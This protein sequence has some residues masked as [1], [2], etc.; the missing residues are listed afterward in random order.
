MNETNPILLCLPEYKGCIFSVSCL[1]MPVQT[2]F[3]DLALSQMRG[4]R[5]KYP[6]CMACGAHGCRCFSY[7]APSETAP[8]YKEWHGHE[9]IILCK[10]CSKMWLKF[11]ED[12]QASGKD[13]DEA[14]TIGNEKLFTKIDEFQGLLLS[15]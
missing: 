13:G 8:H 10:E 12:A 7:N 11:I 4:Y 6:A 9:Y 3:L 5:I 14:I 15:D 1:N 2:F